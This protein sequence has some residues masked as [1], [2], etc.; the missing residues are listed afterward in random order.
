MQGL[1][2]NSGSEIDCTSFLNLDNLDIKA[3]SGSEVNLKVQIKTLHANVAEGATIT[4]EGL[5]NSQE[6]DASTRGIF[7]AYDLIP[8]R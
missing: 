3:G 4:L 1:T 6:I 7:N 2:L 8:K 5:C